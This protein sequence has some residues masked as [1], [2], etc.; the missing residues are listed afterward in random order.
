MDYTNGFLPDSWT[1]VF[2]Q[3]KPLIP[4]I[5]QLITAIAIIIVGCFGEIHVGTP[6]WSGILYTLSGT[7]LC[8]LYIWKLKKLEIISV[9]TVILSI[10]ASVAAIVIYSLEFS[11]PQLFPHNESDVVLTY[12]VDVSILGLCSFQL[13]ISVWILI[14][15]LL[16]RKAA[17]H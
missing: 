9:L 5:I 11:Y 3:Q 8:I 10:L 16:T 4:A 7:S 17:A 1:Q 15:L 2:L 13:G 14:I 12:R 6:W